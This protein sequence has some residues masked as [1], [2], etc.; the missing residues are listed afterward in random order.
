MTTHN[1]YLEGQLLIATPNITGSSFK[2]S[3]ILI[4]AH[5]KDGA[6]GLIINHTLENVHYEELFEQLNLERKALLQSLPVHY[7]GPVEINRGFVVFEHNGQ[8]LDEAMITVGDI[9]ISGSLKLLQAIAEGTGPTKRL[10]ALG[11]AGWAPGQLEEEI[12]GNSWLSVP[13]DNAIIFDLNNIGKWQR[14]ALKYG[15][16]IYKLSSEAGHA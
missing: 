14:A 8:F 13:A 9:A 11:Y 2:Q 12:Q 6:M 1:G 10:L 15:I 7:G 16:D 5:S 4:C 3:V